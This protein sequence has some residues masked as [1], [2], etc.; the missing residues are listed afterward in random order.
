MTVFRFYARPLW[1]GDYQSRYGVLREI[2]GGNG[3]K[4]T[5]NAS[6]GRMTSPRSGASLGADL[7]SGNECRFSTL[8]ASFK[9]DADL[10]RA[11]TSTRG[12]MYRHTHAPIAYAE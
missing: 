11:V 7:E 5:R 2:G 10:A 12:R 9:R 1:S 3:D 6:T 4:W 8:V